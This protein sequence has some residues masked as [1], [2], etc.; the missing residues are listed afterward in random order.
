MPL[1][2]STQ[3]SELQVKCSNTKISWEQALVNNES[4][5]IKVANFTVNE[6]ISCASAVQSE[7]CL[8]VNQLLELRRDEFIGFLL[9]FFQ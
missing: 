1:R 3:N 2:K 6:V 7:F 5:T 9:Q 8:P 4:G